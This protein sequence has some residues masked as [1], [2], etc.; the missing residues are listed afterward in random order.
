MYSGNAAYATYYGADLSTA[1][2][3][4]AYQDQLLDQLIGTEVKAYQAS[5]AGVTLTDEELE[6]AKTNA[7]STYDDFYQQFVDAA[8]DS[9]ATDV[10]AYAN[11]ILTETLAKNGKTLTAIKKEFLDSA[12]KE[13]LVNKHTEGLLAGVTPAEQ[14]IRE[15]YDEEL[16]AQ[17][18]EFASSPASFFTYQTYY[19]YGYTC[20]PLTTPEGL[21]YVRHI[22]VEGEAAANELLDKIRQGADFEE[23]LAEYNTDPGMQA[24]EN[25]QGYLVGAGA[26]FVEPFLNAALALEKE[27]DVSGAVQSDYG[28][29]IIKR[30]KDAVPGTI[31]YDTIKAAFET[32]ATDRIKSDYYAKLLDEWMHGDYVARYPENY[33]YIGK[34]ALEG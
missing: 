4:E 1:E 9:G 34:S 32:Y 18:T 21:F 2:G 6:T 22:L 29:H 5:L 14:E 3:I 33:R 30:M 15:L 20:L 19:S 12:K 31:P 8:Q 23:L 7:Q 24:E 25:K 28:Y 11:K 10:N 27:G 17:Q 16:S 13:L 26:S